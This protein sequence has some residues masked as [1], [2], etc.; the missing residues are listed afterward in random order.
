M[1]FRMRPA[2]PADIDGIA[3]LLRDAFDGSADAWYIKR[4]L[5][6]WKFFE[7]VRLDGRT[8]SH[9]LLQDD[10]IVGHCRTSP[11]SLVVPSASSTASGSRLSAICFMDWVAK[12]GMPGAGITLMKKLMA[13]A[14]VAVVVGGSEATR[15]IIP[16]LGY[17]LRQT[18]GVFARVIRPV[19]QARERPASVLWKAAARFVR[20]AAWSRTPLGPIGPEWHAS[21]VAAFEAAPPE[22]A[23][24][25]YPEHTADY[26]NYWLRCPA[27]RMEGFE[28]H[29]G[30]ERVGS[31]LISRVAG[32]ARV[33]GIWLRAATEREWAYGYRL[34][35]R[36]AAEDPATCE[37]LGYASTPVVE[38]ALEI[39]GFRRRDVRRLFVSDPHHRLPSEAAIAWDAIDDDAPYFFDPAFPFLTWNARTRRRSKR[40]RRAPSWTDCCKAA[41]VDTAHMPGARLNLVVYTSVSA[42]LLQHLLWRLATDLPDVNVVGV[43]YAADSSVTRAGWF[44]RVRTAPGTLAERALDGTLRFMHAAPRYPNGEPLSDAQVMAAWSQ[45]GVEFHVTPDFHDAQSLT[46]V[47]RMGAHLG[48]A[49]GVRCLQPVLLNLPARGSLILENDNLSAGASSRS[50]RLQELEGERAA[51]TMTMTVRRMAREVDSEVVLGR[52]SFPIEP[53]DTR[54]SVRLKAAVFGVDLL[55]SVLRDEALGPVERGQPAA[56]TVSTHGEPHQT[57]ARLPDAVTSPRR[58]RPKYMRPLRKRLLRALVLPFLSVRNQMRRRLARFPVIVLYHHLT[59]DRDKCMGLPTAVFAEHVR[60]LKKHYRIVSLPEAVTLLQRGTITAPTVVLTL[61]DGYADNFSGLR[62]IAEI[63]RVPMT[64]LVCTAHVA[65]KSELAHDIARGEHGFPSMGWEEVRHLDQHGVTIGSH[66]R[67]HLNCGTSDRT[68]LVDEIAGSRE[69]L[70]NALGH[71]VEIFA[72]PKGKP[73]NISPLAFTIARQHYSVVMSAAGGEN[74]G[75]ITLPAEIRRYAHPDSLLELEMQLQG[76]L[77]RAVPYRPTASDD[78]ATPHGVDR[79]AAAHLGAEGGL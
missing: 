37:V 33:A 70:E 16:K 42:E 27:A 38:G 54:E 52:R 49:Y 1:A 48:L 76:V 41:M 2:S 56:K 15:R 9:V 12:R 24:S 13:D 62:A 57:D 36:A 34:A 20:N 55:V 68:Q 53:F 72:F 30:A 60:Y 73:H 66:T 21:R 65:D 7:P 8:R 39:A 61:D 58:W 79:S 22:R 32:Q 35:A 4:S 23:D 77:D 47:R 71:S 17:S 14:D 5:L 64:I 10:S 67:T 26:L 44:D 40:R 43:L 18:L 69:D 29:R 75:P 63:E 28:I 25:V 46:F 3:A 19:R 31:F 59:C 50:R 11:V 78:V 6:E 51:Q 74:F 45:R